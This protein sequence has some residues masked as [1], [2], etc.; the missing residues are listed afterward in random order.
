M[1]DEELLLKELKTLLSNPNVKMTIRCFIGALGSLP[2]VEGATSS[3]GNLLN[4][5]WEW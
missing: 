2:V 1:T 3:L 4:V 5:Y